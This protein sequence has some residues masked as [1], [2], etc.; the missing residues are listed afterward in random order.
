MPILTNPKH[1][2]FAQA[3]VRGDSGRV[4]YR[5]AGYEAN[6]DA[7]DAAASRLLATVKV[8][9]RVGELRERTET[10]SKTVLTKAWIIEQ[11][12]QLKRKAEEK[13]AYAAAVRCVELLG[14]EVN[15]FVEKKEVGLPGEFSDMRDDELVAI[16]RS[17]IP[18]RLG[19]SGSRSKGT[20]AQ[21][22]KETMQ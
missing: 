1:E 13:G 9:A 3:I 12:I 7:C 8:K 15:A 6:D 16:V 5:S 21:S 19:E 2:L 22:H 17:A 18:S 11:A 10:A 20:G 4:A 14:R